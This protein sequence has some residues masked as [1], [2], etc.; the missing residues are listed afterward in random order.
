MDKQ[1][2]ICYKQSLSYYSFPEIWVLM[3]VQFSSGMIYLALS[4]E[5]NTNLLHQKTWYIPYIA[6]RS[7]VN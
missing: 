2:E 6:P 5:L 4:R 7:K 3:Q 1:E